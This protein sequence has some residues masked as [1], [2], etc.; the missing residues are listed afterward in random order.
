MHARFRIRDALTDEELERLRPLVEDEIPPLGDKSREYLSWKEWRGD[1]RAVMRALPGK[2]LELTGTS[3]PAGF[4]AI[5]DRLEALLKVAA[6]GEE[7]LNKRVHVHV[8]GFT[9]MSVDEVIVRVDWCTEALREDLD[10][11]W[12][13]VAV[14]PQ[15]DQRRPD[16]V[17]GRTKV[18]P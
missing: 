6:H 12:R 16:Y 7:H 3:D 11:K 13:I 2:T 10:N 15:P 9:L 14:C 17:L 1:V 8:P 5:A 4:L 18:L